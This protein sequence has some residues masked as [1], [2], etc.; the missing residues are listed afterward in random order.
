M[1]MQAPQPVT[2][3]AQAMSDTLWIDSVE[4]AI[5]DFVTRQPLPPTLSEAVLYATLGPG[6]RVRPLLMLRCCEA[7]GGHA[8]SPGLLDA[9]GAM[10]LIHGFSLVHDDLPAMDDDDLRRGRPTLHKATDEATAILAGDAMMALAFQWVATAGEPTVAAAITRQLATA[11]TEMISGQV[12]DTLGLPATDSAIPEMDQLNAIH[13]QKTGALLRACAGIGATVAKADTVQA[14]ALQS[15]AEAIGLMY[16]VV[17][18]LLDVTSTDATMGKATHKDAAAGKLTY[19]GL[20]GIEATRT[21]ADRLLND[22]LSAIVDLGSP[23]DPLREMARQL[24]TR[25]R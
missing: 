16:Q 11:T 13:R 22:A 24:A 21:E 10:E 14:A 15:Y 3:M 5:R 4:A 25:S 17:D 19:P 6:K 7:V 2:D 9:A 20:I 12:L 23:A 8:Q 1:A 18:D